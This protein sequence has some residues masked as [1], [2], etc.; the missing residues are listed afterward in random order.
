MNSISQSPGHLN[1]EMILPVYRFRWCDAVIILM[2]LSASLFSLPT[3]QALSPDTVSIF[4]ENRLIATY[5]LNRDDTI[6]VPG[7]RGPVEIVIR[8]GK[9]AVSRA[10]CP[11]GICMKTGA[12][13]APHAQIICA[14]NHILVTITSSAPDTIDAVAR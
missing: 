6:S 3:L 4:R 12:V 2:I 9:V 7:A 14:P 10:N 5:P 1:Q 11:H 8:N 13:N